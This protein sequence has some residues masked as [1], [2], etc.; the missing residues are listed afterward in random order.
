MNTVLSLCVIILGLV[1][2]SFLN[3]VALRGEYRASKGGS[4]CPHCSHS[5][6][7]YE[8]IPVASYL[9]L[10]GKCRSCKTP[11]S[12]RYPIIEIL[13]AG[14][15]YITFATSQNPIIAATILF[16]VMLSVLLAIVDCDHYILPAR[17][18][19]PMIIVSVFLVF[20]TKSL[21]LSVFI[22]MLLGIAAVAGPLWLLNVVSR[23]RWLGF[24]DVRFG[25][26]MGILLGPALGA[27]ALLLSF[28]FGAFFSIMI[29][30]IQKFWS[31]ELR[32]SSM[33][34]FGPFLIFA[35]WLVYFLNLDILEVVSFF[36]RI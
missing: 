3:V 21:H 34:P 12:V 36:S 31:G 18:I 2:G 25:I 14:V 9:F 6:S 27:A 5:L 4:K 35:T 10:G 32:F 15:F 7:W 22:E 19:H 33:I 26:F 28:W 29:L 30:A 11:L 20:F 1:V 24:G 17:Y 13:T 16:L 8:L 23:G